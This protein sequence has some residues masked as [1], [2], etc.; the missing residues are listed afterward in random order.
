MNAPS[1]PKLSD[2]CKS[3]KDVQHIVDLLDTNGCLTPHLLEVGAGLLKKPNTFAEE[4]NLLIKQYLP[5]HQKNYVLNG[6]TDEYRSYGVYIAGDDIGERNCSAE[7]Q[8]LFNGSV[9]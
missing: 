6:M 3:A 8:K 4:L 9:P 7:L 5:S 2:Y 1:P